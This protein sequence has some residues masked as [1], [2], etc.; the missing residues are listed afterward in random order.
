M[1]RRAA[2]ITSWPECAGSRATDECAAPSDSIQTDRPR[3]L[4]LVDVAQTRS[5]EGAEQEKTGHVK[6]KKNQA[7]NKRSVRLRL[8][9][10]RGRAALLRSDSR[11]RTGASQINVTFND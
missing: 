2:E 8:G 1:K 9:E 5:C 3:L 4:L 10:A 6:G 11:R 7:G